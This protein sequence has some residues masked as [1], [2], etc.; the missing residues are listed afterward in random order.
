MRVLPWGEAPQKPGNTCATVPEYRRAAALHPTDRTPHGVRGP[1]A[2][3]PRHHSGVKVITTLSSPWT[4][5]VNAEPLTWAALL[6]FEAPEPVACCCVV[7]A[8]P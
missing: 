7:A 1:A 2:L 8:L 5:D 3:S 6:W 4:T